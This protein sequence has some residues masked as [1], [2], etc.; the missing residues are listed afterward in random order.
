MSIKMGYSQPTAEDPPLTKPQLELSVS[1]DAAI[2]LVL[3][4]T[5]FLT[6]VIKPIIVKYIYK[7]F[8]PIEEEKRINTILCQ[9]SGLTGAERVRLAIFHNGGFGY[10]GYRLI[11]LSLSN[12]YV[13]P[14]CYSPAYNFKDFPI[15]RITEELEALQK[16]DEWVC[17]PLSSKLPQACQD[18]L[19][20]NNIGVLCNRMITLGDIPVAIVSIQY[21]GPPRAPILTD[22]S[23]TRVDTLYYE[24]SEI[25]R[26]RIVAPSPWKILIG[27]I[28]GIVK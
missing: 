18:Y 2:T 1:I 21:L 11:K 14:E 28:L 24:L 4:F 22:T 12:S 15:G 16:A 19:K 27:R 25:I 13:A 3:L 6:K 10:T 17:T 7:S 9:M 5:L 20:R 23:Q 26:T 8:R